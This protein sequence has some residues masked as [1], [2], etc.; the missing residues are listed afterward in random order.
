MVFTEEGGKLNTINVIEGTNTVQIIGTNLE[1]TI[2]FVAQGD[3][4]LV[5]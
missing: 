3:F 2:N 1:N 4:E 5:E